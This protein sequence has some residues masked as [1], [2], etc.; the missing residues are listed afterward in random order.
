MNYEEFWQPLQQ[1]Y[2]AGEARAVARMVLE[3]GFQLTLSDIICGKVTQL[4]AK[5]QAELQ[6]IQ[7]RLLEGEPVQHVLG[8]ADFGSRQ[9]MVSPSVLIPRPETYELCQWIVA[10]MSRFEHGFPILDIGTGSGCIACTLAAELP[11]AEVTA[12]DVSEEAL[13]VACE[14]AKRASVLV[15]FEHQDA[16]HAPEDHER[17]RII[18]SNPPYI[19]DREKASMERNVL[20]YEPHLA[21]FVPDDDPLQFYRAIAS[22][23]ATALLRDGSLYFEINSLY[24]HETESMLH[25]MGFCQI[26]TREDQFGRQRFVKAVRP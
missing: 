9:F 15:S 18:V 14:N 3:M 19:C 12:W 22:Y 1:V 26:E 6:E 17:W 20:A 16:L 11:N 5:Q 24:A 21:L 25:S 7:R 23:A 2:D 10:D 13:N 4:S 8:V